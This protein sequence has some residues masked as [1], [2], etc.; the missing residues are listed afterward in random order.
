MPTPLSTSLRR[1]LCLAM[2]PCAAAAVPIEPD[3]PV[4]D[5]LQRLEIQGLAPAGFGGVRPWDSRDILSRLE[6]A[7]A[8]EAELRPWDRNRLRSFLEEFSPERRRAATRLHVENERLA[9]FAGATY[10]TGG[11]WRDSLPKSQRFAFGSLTPWIEADYRDRLYAVSS[12]TVGM[13]RDHLARFTETY[14]PQR[15]MPYNTNR[16]G[17]NGIPQ[18][19]STF[20]GFR[21][22]FGYGD[23]TLRV[24]AGQDWNRFG[25]GHWQTA[26]LGTHGYIWAQD[27]LPRSDSVGFLGANQ[28]EKF[29]R[30]YRFPGESAPMPQL[31]LSVQGKNFTYVKIV[32]QRDGILS[33]SVTVISHRLVV[34]PFPSL[35]LG[36]T[37][38]AA[39]GGRIP[40]LA[41][42]L[43]LVPLKFQEHNGRG[44]DNIAMAFDAEWTWREHGRFYGELFLDDFSGPPLDYWGN[45]LAYTLGVEWENPF[46]LPAV[47][48]AEFA[49]VDPWV[50]TH[51]LHDTQLQHSGALLGSRLPANAL[52]LWTE[53]VFPLPKDVEASVQWFSRLRDLRSRGSSP[54]DVF[55]PSS[56]SKTKLFLADSAVET[57]HEGNIILS[58]AWRR[59]LNLRA[60]GGFIWVTDWK[61]QS[62]RNLVSPQIQGEIYLRY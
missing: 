7:F 49:E 56:D 53:A 12:A 57:R 59:T 28:P 35:V 5:F 3:H 39:L 9:A 46:R 62:G 30:G 50:F 27:S 41:Y 54:F 31:R 29:R 18:N 52:A 19:V 15:G 22:L 47:W 44:R 37:E 45:K 11:V 25:P 32:A 13:E 21:A 24:E 58:W 20:D 2:L 33:R 61:G 42:W 34:R 40:D 43:P 6:A 51:H 55:D 4:Y 17:K 8:H 36:G 26:T 60:G 38:I 1:A 10:Y 14:D 23:G 48:R 16:E